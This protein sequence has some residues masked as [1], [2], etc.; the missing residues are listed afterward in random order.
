MLND[1]NRAF[2]VLGVGVA[3]AKQMFG[4]EAGC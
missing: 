2:V 1:A 3:V 4:G